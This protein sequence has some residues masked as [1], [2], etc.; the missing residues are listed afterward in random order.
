MGDDSLFFFCDVLPN[1]QPGNMTQRHDFSFK[2]A[3]YRLCLNQTPIE[4][5]A[6]AFAES[7]ETFSLPGLARKLIS[8]I[9]PALS[10][11]RAQAY[12]CLS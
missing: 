4:G 12:P 6:H 3:V 7:L 8:T 5:L 10:N 11:H 2:C 9:M 1:I